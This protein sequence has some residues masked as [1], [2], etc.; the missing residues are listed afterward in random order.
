LNHLVVTA[1]DFGLSEEVNEAIEVAH[2]TGLL[3]AA[4]LMVA[5]P[6]AS[7]ADEVRKW[8]REQG[9]ISMRVRAGEAKHPETGEWVDVGLPFGPKP[10]L[11]LAFLNTQA[12]LTNSNTI[13]VEDSLTSF[14]DR[15]GFT[16]DGRTIRTVKEQLTRLCAS[17][18]TFGTAKDGR[19]W[20][21]GGRVVRGFELWF[22]KNEAQRVL[23]PT[24]VELSLDYFQSLREHAVPLNLE[25]LGALKES[26][27]AL[28]IYNMAGA[29][30]LAR[31][32]EGSRLHHLGRS[33]RPVRP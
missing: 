9:R 14:T 31:S 25:A 13:E 8:H 33:Q 15:I 29:A 24:L 4:G 3:R 12:I 21:T 6:A 10:R 28:D 19:S 20:T 16:N 17:D 7:D 22:P 18:F 30:P 32:P 2:C 5:G 26:A 23:W 1:D 11:I 27:L